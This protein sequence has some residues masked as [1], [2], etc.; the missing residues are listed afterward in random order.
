[1]SDKWQWEFLGFESAAEGR[2]VQAWYD[3]LDE[4]QRLDIILLCEYLAEMTNKRWK[5]PEYDPLRGE[6]GISEIRAS[7]ARSG[8]GILYGRIY[9]V[10]SWRQYQGS[11]I[12]LHG[13]NKEVKNDRDGKAI[14]RERLEQLERGEAKVHE[15]DFSTSFGANAHEKSGGK[16]SIR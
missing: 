8:E 12:F 7:D 16:G 6:G 13:T 1:M 14:A 11:Y 9:G 3:S 15:F 2:P 4:D 10:R 5:L